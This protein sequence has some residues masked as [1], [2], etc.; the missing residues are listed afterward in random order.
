MGSAGLQNPNQCWRMQ[1]HLHNTQP[2]GLVMLCD[3]RLD[4]INVIDLSFKWHINFTE[5]NNV[6]VYFASWTNDHWLHISE[7]FLTPIVSL[8]GTGLTSLMLFIQF[9]MFSKDFSSV[10]SYTRMMPCRR[11]DRKEW[12]KKRSG[13]SEHDLCGVCGPTMAPL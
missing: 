13:A 12:A 2:G 9:W 11:E 8:G 6:W 1:T 10:M 3:D 4:C 5:L 7:R